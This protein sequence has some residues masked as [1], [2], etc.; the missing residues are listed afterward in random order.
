MFYK[1]EGKRY[2]HPQKT[3]LRVPL[4]SVP[5]NQTPACGDSGP[6]RKHRPSWTGHAPVDRQGPH[7]AS[8][9]LH[10]GGVRVWAQAGP[11]P[12]WGTLLPP[13]AISSYGLGTRA[14]QLRQASYNRQERSMQQE[15]QFP[16]LTQTNSIH[17]NKPPDLCGPPSFHLEI[18]GL[19]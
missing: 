7:G 5:V 10:S 19:K 18:E 15:F 6:I 13:T 4:I 16:F 1:N 9:A 2:N 12:G 11:P 3:A 14:R 8:L 17:L